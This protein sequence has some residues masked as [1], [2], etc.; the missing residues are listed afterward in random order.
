MWEYKL[1][2]SG[3]ELQHHGVKGMR[4]GVR[5]YQNED[6][7]YTSAG[8][9]RYAKKAVTQMRNLSQ[10]IQQIDAARRKA[11]ER[12]NRVKRYYELLAKPDPRVTGRVEY[13]PPKVPNY[14]KTNDYELP[15]M[16]ENVRSVYGQD[17]LRKD[18]ATKKKNINDMTDDELLKDNR[19]RAL[20]NQYKKNHQAPKSKVQS[21]KEAVDQTQ[22]AVTQ[23]RDLSRQMEA[24][25]R[26]TTPVDLSEYSDDEL[27]KAINRK[28]LERQYND[29]FKDQDTISSGQAKVDRVLSYAGTGLALTST[30]LGIA[31]AVKQLSDA[32]S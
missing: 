23:M 29:L 26:R 8:K 9:A 19:R 7:S 24:A 28:N 30:A 18:G 3:E 4:W 31:V 13:D 20:E 17:P 27:R 25:R 14:G 6:G 2:N 11:M 32:A 12:E 1:I 21:A 16:P 22:K 15:K 10:Q 5:R